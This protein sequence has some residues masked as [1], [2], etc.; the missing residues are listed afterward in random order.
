VTVAVAELAGANGMRFLVHRTNA[1]QT[2]S[3]AGSVA[4]KDGVVTVGV[5]PLEL[6]TLRSVGDR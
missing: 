4:L 2:N 5:A 1:T 3:A 6:V